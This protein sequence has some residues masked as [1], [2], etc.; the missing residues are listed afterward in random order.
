MEITGASNPGDS[1]WTLREW[2]TEAAGGPPDPAAVL[3]V[4]VKAK[5][6]R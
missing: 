2:K 4:F 1:I 5:A 3:E 6:T